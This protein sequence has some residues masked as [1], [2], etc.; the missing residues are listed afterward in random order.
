MVGIG[1]A[2]RYQITALM[3]WCFRYKQNFSTTCPHDRLDGLL[4]EV[5]P[6]QLAGTWPCPAAP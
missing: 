2:G 3:V 6:P 5:A 4:P 1:G